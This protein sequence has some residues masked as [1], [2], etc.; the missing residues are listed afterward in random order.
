MK[1]KKKLIF[2]SLGVVILLITFFLSY[3]LYQ[4]NINNKINNFSSYINEYKQ[5]IAK[6]YLSDNQKNYN[7]LIAEAEQTIYDKEHKKIA[8]LTTSLNELKEKVLAENNDSLSNFSNY[9]NTYKE[10]I[11]NYNLDDS[12]ENYDNLIAEAEQAIVNKDYK[13]VDSLTSNLNQ[14]KEEVLNK[15]IEVLSNTIAEL[16]GI[17]ISKI[18]DKDSINSKIEEIKKLKDEKLFIQ[19]TELANTL[20]ADINNKLEIIKQNELSQSEEIFSKKKALKYLSENKNLSGFL[21]NNIL[22]EYDNGDFLVASKTSN[23]ESF[24]VYLT[25][26]DDLSYNFQIKSI[27]NDPISGKVSSGIALGIVYSDGKVEE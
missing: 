4:K 2:I 25:K 16:E 12:K 10:E 11:A 27:I 6:Y 19:A 23:G 13:N 15:N 18:S 9:L 5:E 20:K 14:F 26:L 1:N 21:T 22:K 3:T 7:N 17:D 24:E 8:S